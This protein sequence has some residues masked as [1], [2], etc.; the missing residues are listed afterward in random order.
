[1]KSPN[2]TESKVAK[3]IKYGQIDPKTDEPRLTASVYLRNIKKEG[4]KKKSNDKN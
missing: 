3:Y 2:L 1:M 4:T